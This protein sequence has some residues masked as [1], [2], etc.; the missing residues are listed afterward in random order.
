MRVLL[1]L[2]GVLCAFL[3]GYDLVEFIQHG[4]GFYLF[5][6]IVNGILAVVDLWLGVE[7]L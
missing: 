3:F 7:D 6:A 1:I 4:N 5:M 2:F